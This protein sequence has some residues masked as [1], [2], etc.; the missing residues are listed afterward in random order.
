MIFSVQRFLEDHFERRGLEDV[1]QYAI[2]VA[3]V[4]ERLG[5]RARNLSIGMRQSV[6]E[7]SE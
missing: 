4:V 6:I 5:L 3:N 7:F 2:Q 1:D